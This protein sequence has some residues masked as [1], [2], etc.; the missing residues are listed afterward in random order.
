MSFEDDE[1]LQ[2]FIEESLEHLADIEND[3]LAIEERG[4]DIDVELVNKVFRAAHSIKGGAGFMGLTVIQDLAHAAENVLGLIRAEK[5]TPTPEIVNTLLLASDQLQQLIED[6]GNSNSVDINSHVSALNLIF[7]QG[8][9]AP[10]GDQPVA[11]AAADEP[12]PIEEGTVEAESPPQEAAPFYLD[13]ELIKP[14]PVAEVEPEPIPEPQADPV[15]EALPE[16]APLPQQEKAQKKPSKQAAVPVTKQDT[17]IRVTVSLLDQ[18]MNLAGELV[19][20]RNQLLQTISSGDGRNAEAVGQRI[21]LVTSELQEAIMLT[22]MQPIGNVFNKFPRVVRDLSKKLDKQMDLTIVGKDVELDKTIIEAINDPLTHLVRNSVDHGVERPADRVKKGKDARGLIVLKAYH[23]AGQVV[24]E[25]SDD[26]K[27][28]D[29][30]ALAE[31]AIKKGLIT[32]EQANVLSEKERINL[33]LLPGFS[34]AEQVTDVSGRGVGMDVVKTNLDQ[35]GGS[36]EI[37]SEVGKGS[38]ISIKLPLTLAIIPCQ[39]I[40]TGGERYA[41]PQVNLEELLRIPASRIKERIERVGDA[42]VVRLRGNLLPLI[43]MADVFEIERTYFDPV[44]EETRLDRREN[45]ADRRS[46]STPLKTDQEEQEEAEAARKQQEQPRKGDRRQSVASAMNIVVVSTGAMKYGLIVDQ[47]QDSEEIVIKP[48]GRHLQQ[49][50]GYAGAT[51]MGDGRIALI[52]DVSSIA[53]MAGL[54]SL[55]GSERAAELA[56][57]AKDAITKTRDKQALLTFSSAPTEFFGVPLNQVERVEKIKQDDVEDVGGRRVMQYRGGTLPLVSI[58]EVAMVQPMDIQENLLVI[59]FHLA[60]RDV[61]L[62]ATGPIDAIEISSDID[63]VTLKQTGIMGSSIIGEKTTM[64]VDIF[65]IVQTIN[66]QW[67]EELTASGSFEDEEVAPTILIVEDSNFFRNQVKGYMEEAG[68]QVLEAEDGLEALQVLEENISE[69]TMVVT[70]I[71]M[72]N[73]DGFE[74]TEKIKNNPEYA[75]LP[76]IALT[77]LAADE[78]IARGKSVGVDEYHIK[79]D[80]ERLMKS[81]HK[82]AKECSLA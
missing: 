58:D 2:G 13:E 75:H 54:T 38:T 9:P 70:D 49:C 36:I 8:E 45:V 64:L 42:E 34:T 74:L 23:A 63:D 79:L 65:E 69:I 62:L 43:R 57:A 20:S 15:A 46:K 68:F 5:L 59:V 14:E 55:E 82:Y 81:V 12:A 72:P 52:L 11:E 6:T 29:G 56:D 18:L 47:L 53:G 60:G 24:I 37:D 16:P 22:R 77:T 78:D 51:I 41:I 21:D 28:I 1:I 67:F 27:G 44:S 76:V 80:K 35:L 10:G 32:Q 31:T 39:I 17:S 4:A 30:D 26:G 7:E 66:P 25:I 40:M 19:L 61:G 50:Q 71:E 73:M 3:L 48:L 33:I